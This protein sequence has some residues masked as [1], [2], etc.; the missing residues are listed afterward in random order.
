[1]FRKAFQQ[2]TEQNRLIQMVLVFTLLFAA[3]HVSLHDF[4]SGDG[5][6]VHDECEVCRLNHV[7]VAA[8]A[9][10]SLLAPLQTLAYAPPVADTEYQYSHLLLVQWARAPPLS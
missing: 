5:Q 4:V 1:M 7:P 9:T 8:L 3:A 2:R 6:N 10:P